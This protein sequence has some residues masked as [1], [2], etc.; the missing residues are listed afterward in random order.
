MMERRLTHV[1]WMDIRDRMQAGERRLMLQAGSLEAHGSIP[2]GTDIFIPGYLCG[3]LAEPLASW[4]A[5][6]I[7]YG[8]TRSLAAYPGTV[9]IEPAAF[10]AYLA[11]V[12]RSFARQGFTE[13]L[14]LN[15]HGGHTAQL[16]E[17]AGA[18]HVETGA[19]I[20]AV[21]WWTECY[22]LCL[23][24]LGVPGG[25]AGADEA[26]MVRAA[27]PGLV[28]PARD[29]D[30]KGWVGRAST[31]AFPVPGSLIS[32]TPEGLTVIHDEAACRAYVEASVQ[33]LE[34]VLQ[35][36]LEGWSVFGETLPV[37]PVRI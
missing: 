7:P 14:I 1:N 21:D 32:T 13:I 23:K 10:S 6:C 2:Q 22:D 29:K 11:D 8:V 30:V 28:T 16:R 37:G 19:R 27:E 34:Q 4:I 31:A 15:G 18:V 36:V 9:H 35:S 24:H 25:H 12:L 20:A 5:P 33:R 17:T 26:A 3:R